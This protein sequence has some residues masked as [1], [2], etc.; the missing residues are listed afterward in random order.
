MWYILVAC[1]LK[2]HELWYVAA[3]STL[4]LLIVLIGA[5]PGAGGG[6]ELGELPLWASLDGLTLA[7]SNVAFEKTAMGLAYFLCM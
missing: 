3:R 4:G 1:Q 5:R 6:E 7:V 2:Y